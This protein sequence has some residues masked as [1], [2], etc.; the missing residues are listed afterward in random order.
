[1]ARSRRGNVQQCPQQRSYSSPVQQPRYHCDYVDGHVP[2]H[3][4]LYI[5]ACTYVPHLMHR[6]NALAPWPALL[7]CQA[8]MPVQLHTTSPHIAPAPVTIVWR[9]QL[10]CAGGTKHCQ[11][12]W[13]RYDIGRARARTAG[14]SACAS[15]CVMAGGQD[16]PHLLLPGMCRTVRHSSRHPP[17]QCAASTDMLWMVSQLPADRR[18]V[19]SW[20]FLHACIHSCVCS[21]CAHR[22]P[23][24]PHGPLTTCASSTRSRVPQD[25][26]I[27]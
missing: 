2:V 25:H 23:A 17:Q 22:S 6:I 19:P 4:C 24:Q 13:Y 10:C 18:H 7:R 20:R 16:L 15:V 1:M 9:S 5:C 12:V 21:Q 14:S 27:A 8:A 11:H 3:M 26:T